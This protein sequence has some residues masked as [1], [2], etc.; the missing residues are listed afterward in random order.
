MTNK[1]IDEDALLVD[2]NILD[3]YLKDIL[4]RKSFISHF[5][6]MINNIG[7][8]NNII[9]LEGSWGEGKTIFVKQA[10]NLLMA[11][12]QDNREYTKHI[13]SKYIDNKTMENIPKDVIPIY[14]DAWKLDRVNNPTLAIAYEIVKSLDLKWKK[15]T[16]VDKSSLI[17]S[18]TELAASCAV[19]SEMAYG[20]PALGT[21]A[22]SAGTAISNLV[23]TKTSFK[24]FD[25]L[26]T[27][28]NEI[29]FDESLAE[30]FREATNNKQQRIVIFIDELDRCNPTFAVRL[31]EDIKHYFNQEN[32][33]FVFSINIHELQN[34]LKKYYGESFDSYRYLDRFFDIRLQL[35]A[36]SPLNYYNYI[37]HNNTDEPLMMIDFISLDMIQNFK[38][39]LREIERFSLMVN[40][41]IDQN[42]LLARGSAEANCHSYI[43]LLM[44]IALIA[45]KLCDGKHFLTSIQMREEQFFV[46]YFKRI[47]DK[48]HNRD[49]LKAS[50]EKWNE[51]SYIQNNDIYISFDDRV[52][53][54]YQLVFSDSDLIASPTTK[55]LSQV[56]NWYSTKKTVWN[57]LTLM[58][59]ISNYDAISK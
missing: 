8:K 23:S 33:I 13:W 35:P 28:K 24:T 18:I 49:I 39:S 48:L 16:W 53:Q 2:E 26:E 31:L 20:I 50:E 42:K 58:S 1:S 32:I 46:D 37:N 41:A 25:Y 38:M 21:L 59:N 9:A 19:L 7:N 54:I 45:L 34:T 43:V 6:R 15:S 47:T 4:H 17:K 56:D 52:K 5:I 22:S 11:G 40:I 14:F 55:F 44:G 30:L 27:I 10:I 57:I 12:H 51:T 3:L 36:I 29:S